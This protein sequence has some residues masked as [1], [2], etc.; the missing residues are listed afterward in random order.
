MT[1]EKI[2]G[3]TE[4]TSLSGTDIFLAIQGGI[5]K[6]ITVANT[7]ASIAPDAS[8]SVKGVVQLT[9]TYSGSSQT[10]AGTQKAIN[11]G[12]AT[13]EASITKLSVSKGGTN[14]SVALTN[15]KLIASSGDAI[16]ESAIDTPNQNLGTTNSVTFSSVAL[17][18]NLSV[19]GI[20]G[21]TA[22]PSFT[23]DTQIIDKKYADDLVPTKGN[24]TEATSSALTIVGGTNA[25]F[26]SGTTIQVKTATTAVSGTVMLSNSYTGTSEVLAV[27]EKALKNGLASVATGAAYWLL[28]GTYNYLYPSTTSVS[29]RSFSSIQLDKVAT[30]A[31][32]SLCIANVLS[33]YNYLWS[34]AYVVGHGVVSN[35]FYDA[36]D[37]S[38]TFYNSSLAAQTTG[39]VK[40]YSLG[41][42]AE[43]SYY[44]DTSINNIT[45]EATDL[46]NSYNNVSSLKFFS[47]YKNDLNAIVSGGAVIG[48]AHGTAAISNIEWLD[49]TDGSVSYVTYPVTDGNTFVQTGCVRF[50]VM[51]VYSGSPAIAQGFFAIIK[52]TVSNNN[53]IQ[54]Y[55]DT[56]GQIKL[57]IYDSVG[58]AIINVS[59]GAWSPVANNVYEFALDVNLT[60]G[61]TRLFINK[62]QFGGTQSATG[63]RDND[64]T[65]LVV[66]NIITENKTSQI[67]IAD[68][69]IYNAPQF[70]SAV[71]SYTSSYYLENTYQRE[72][73]EA[74]LETYQTLADNAFTNILVGSL[75]AKDLPSLYKNV[76][77]SI[78]LLSRTSS[79]FGLMGFEQVPLVTLHGQYNAKTDMFT[80]KSNGTRAWGQVITATTSGMV[81]YKYNVVSAVDVSLQASS[82]LINANKQSAWV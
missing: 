8:T 39:C 25:V 3:L 19:G 72:W 4:T 40:T 46:Y 13:K 26:G 79:A 67:Y 23:V 36:G 45:L 52:S 62:S 21:Y 11:D 71:T 53:L 82:V 81:V 66:G 41:Q 75:D 60:A 48:T 74:S 9:N 56:T 51:P 42:I 17:T 68:F 80:F 78:N 22:H 18:N 31:T 28:N 7:Q 38:Y 14:S 76:G 43:Y 70:A 69:G 54:L 32:S 33:P 2:S 16:V 58:S 47:L 64:F 73:Y 65:T 24:L 30:H 63:T 12:L 15:G 20:A 50:F 49:L 35:G 59:L 37:D 29:I 55:H 1:D 61:K 27:T 44:D 34:S 10:L 6:K 77:S 57:Q 5:N